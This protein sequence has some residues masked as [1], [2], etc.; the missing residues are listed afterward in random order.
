MSSWSRTWIAAGF[1]A[2]DHRDV[3]EYL[4]G[5]QGLGSS[6]P[7]DRWLLRIPGVA[8]AREESWQALASTGVIPLGPRSFA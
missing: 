3:R 5:R 8:A 4:E 1:D 2:L 6:R 7:R